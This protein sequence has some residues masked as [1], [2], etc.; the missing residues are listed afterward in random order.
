MRK[1]H[2]GS[3]GGQ[4]RGEE[5]LS[6]ERIVVTKGKCKGEARIKGSNVAVSTIVREFMKGRS[7]ADLAASFGIDGHD[8]QAALRFDAKLTREERDSAIVDVAERDLYLRQYCDCCSGTGKYDGEP[9]PECNEEAAYEH[10]V[11][12]REKKKV[13]GV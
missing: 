9:C 5:A 11:A 10:M 6:T 12:Q 8:V 3:G 2:G 13:A 7:I 4:G 1:A